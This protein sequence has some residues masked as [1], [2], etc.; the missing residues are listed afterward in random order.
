M[1]LTRVDGC[2]EPS[3]ILHF[4]P[5]FLDSNKKKWLKKKSAPLSRFELIR[6]GIGLETE[7]SCPIPV[8]DISYGRIDF[9]NSLVM[10]N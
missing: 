2:E 7:D 4:R 1:R 10:V 6:A 8:L 3:P 5:V 9:H